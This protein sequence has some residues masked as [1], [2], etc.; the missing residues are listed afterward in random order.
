M[1]DFFLTDIEI[2]DLVNEP[3][4]INQS[5][6]SLIKG[7]KPK[8]R[9]PHI[10]QNSHKFS[11]QNGKGEWLLFIRFNS[12]YPLDFS[13][14][15]E[16]IPESRKKGFRLRRHNGKNHSHTNQLEGD[17]FQDFHIHIATERYQNSSHSDDHY[18]KTTNKYGEFKEA[19][20]CLFEDCKIER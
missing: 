20:E 16:F 4:Q 2:Q 9:Y 17:T 3:K 5:V 6:D 14:G 8:D 13:C 18:A 11:R 10:M 1:K 19:L 12:K 15:L 7:M